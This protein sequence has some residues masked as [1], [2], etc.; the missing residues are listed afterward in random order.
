MRSG[1]RDPPLW[2]V[3]M[4]LSL[5]PPTPVDWQLKQPQAGHGSG[6]GHGPL[7]R[8]SPG[9]HYSIIEYE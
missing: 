7:N 4:K 6:M 3:P 2:K 8:V 1:V 9:S 5:P